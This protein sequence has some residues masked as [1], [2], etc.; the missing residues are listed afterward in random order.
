MLLNDWKTF[1][2]LTDKRSLFQIVFAAIILLIILFSVV[3]I[4]GALAMIVQFN[5]ID[6]PKTLSKYAPWI[7]FFDVL[8][9]FVF[10]NTQFY[11]YYLHFP[12]KRN[13]LIIYYFIRIAFGIRNSMMYLFCF[14][15]N[16]FSPVKHFWLVF[17][18]CLL[19]LLGSILALVLKAAIGSSIGFV[20]LFTVLISVSLFLFLSSWLYFFV[21]ISA[22]L[23]VLYG[24]ILIFYLFRYLFLPLI[25]YQ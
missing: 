11:Q 9:K 7:F 13:V 1:L 23:P 6:I 16:S 19:V 8:Q 15:F 25:K 18:M 24:L 12:I 22:A 5:N 2:R 20:K 21:G 4:A 10:N 14:T 17:F 3:V